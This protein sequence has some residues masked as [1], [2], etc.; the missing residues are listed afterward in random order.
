M[1]CLRMKRYFASL[2]AQRITS[3]FRALVG[4][5]DEGDGRRSQLRLRRGVGLDVAFRQLDFVG[6]MAC[7]IKWAM[8][9]FCCM[10]STS[11]QV[12]CLEE[13]INLQKAG[14]DAAMTLKRAVRILCESRARSSEWI[15]VG[16]LCRRA[17]ERQVA[18]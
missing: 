5:I 10:F 9:P 13:D 1:V 16:V 6:G 17:C 2:P 4:M 11:C 15:D 14:R 8:L 3:L 7:T 18:N 12:G